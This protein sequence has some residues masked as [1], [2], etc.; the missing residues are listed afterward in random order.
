MMQKLT[1]WVFGTATARV[2][3]DT[4]RFL[5][6]AVRSGVVPLEAARDGDSLR[7]TVRARQFSALHAVKLR[8]GAHVRLLEKRGLPFHAARARKRPGLLL[9]AVLAVLLYGFLSG[10]YWGV[11]VEGDAPYSDSEILAAAADAGAFFGARR[12][13]LD[14]Q[15]ARH[16]IEGALPKLAWAAV[17]TDGCF[18]TV[19][20]RGA[21][22]REPAD[23]SAGIYHVRARRGGRI[24]RIEAERGTV[25]AKVGTYAEAGSLLVSAVRTVGDPWGE[26]PLVNL[27]THAKARVFAE[28]RHSFTGTCPLTEEIPEE[29]ILGVR[30]ALCVFGVRIPLT[31]SGAADGAASAYRKT[32]WTLLGRD[33]PVWVEE[34]R[35]AELVPQTVV[36]TEDEALCRARERAE[37]LLENQLGETGRVLSREEHVS[38]SGGAVRVTLRCTL[39]EDIAE[40][41]EMTEAERAEAEAKLLEPPM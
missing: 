17:N 19:S 24:V 12:D 35:T 9:G 38:V 14:A 1:R 40:E 33:L 4:A 25:L 10:Y 15:V 8:T 29:R 36:R 22:P 5:N 18:I 20:V 6:V 41:V 16:A 32:P 11:S 37:A 23:D 7:L 34:L 21:E 39:L 13:S 3:G 27:Y 2:S 26:A 30:R 31:F 28:T